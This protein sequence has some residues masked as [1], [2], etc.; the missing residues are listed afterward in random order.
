MVHEEE[1]RSRS[2]DATSSQQGLLA[3]MFA[4]TRVQIAI[5]RISK[6]FVWVFFLYFNFVSF[7]KLI[8]STSC[9]SFDSPKKLLDLLSD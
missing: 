6:V 7:I 1:H 5:K 3:E 4:W 8:P 2:D 9:L